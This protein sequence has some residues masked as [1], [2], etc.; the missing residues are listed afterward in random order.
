[1]QARGRSLGCVTDDYDG[2]LSVIREVTHRVE[3]RFA[4]IEGGT[5][6]NERVGVLLLHH[7][8]HADCVSRRENL[9]AVVAQ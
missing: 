5:I 2:K 8:I 3:K 4:H 7:F 1:M 9:V 6:Q